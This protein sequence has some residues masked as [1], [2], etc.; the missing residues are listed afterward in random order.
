MTETGHPCA[1]LDASFSIWGGTGLAWTSASPSSA[2]RKTSGQVSA[3]SPQE[4]H[5][6]R[7]ILASISWFLQKQDLPSAALVWAA[8]WDSIPKG[9]S[10]WNCSSPVFPSCLRRADRLPL[11][12][13]PVLT[14]KAGWKTG[15]SQGTSPGQMRAAWTCAAVCS[16]GCALRAAGWKRGFSWMWP[17][18]G[19]TS[20]TSTFPA[21][22]SAG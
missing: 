11:K 17:F 19:A 3:Q 8:R 16:T 20:Q 4:M 2:M 22:R 12:H 14:A 1:A 15:G 5:P 10:G 18:A 13:R 9:V 6:L 7:S 21:G